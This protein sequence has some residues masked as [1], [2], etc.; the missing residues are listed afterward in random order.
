MNLKILGGKTF[1]KKGRK[2]RKEVLEYLGILTFLKCIRNGG[3]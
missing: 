2:L 3:F 1:L